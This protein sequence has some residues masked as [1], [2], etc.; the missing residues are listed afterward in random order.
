LSFAL[1]PDGCDRCEMQD[2]APHLTKERYS[3]LRL[4]PPS[5]QKV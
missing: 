3:P 4:L 1:A 5:R 2:T